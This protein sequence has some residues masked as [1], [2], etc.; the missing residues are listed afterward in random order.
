MPFFKVEVY[1]LYTNTFLVEANDK[2]EAIQKVNSG[3]GVVEDDSLD[4]VEVASSYGMDADTL[5]PM[6]KL[7][8]EIVDK[9][10]IVCGIRSVEETNDWR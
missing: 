5:G 8:R 9:S 4:Y 3:E 2:I 10:D 1:E 6:N 7:P